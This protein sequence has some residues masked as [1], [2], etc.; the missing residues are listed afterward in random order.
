LQR[1][2]WTA[3]PGEETTAEAI[4]R[5]SFNILRVFV[6]V[7]SVLVMLIL[8]TPMIWEWYDQLPQRP[9]K[10]HG[11]GGVELGMD[12]VDVTL[13]LG[14]PLHELED[15]QLGADRARGLIFEDLTVYV[16]G[17]SMEQLKVSQICSASFAEFQ[18]KM[19]FG[20]GADEALVRDRLGAPRSETIADD[21]LSKFSHFSKYNLSIECIK[22][23]ATRFCIQAGHNAG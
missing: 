9:Q 12:K 22:A 18:D 4:V 15:E 21:G 10:L 17:A 5:I 14:A 16:G 7:P 20:F 3:S 1:I 19:G 6:F 13:K 8:A 2:F 23:R 11:Y